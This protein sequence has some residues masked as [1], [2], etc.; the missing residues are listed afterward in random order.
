MRKG[1]T[2]TTFYTRALFQKLAQGDIA[3]A[4][5]VIKTAAE[6]PDVD[7]EAFIH[8]LGILSHAHMLMKGGKKQ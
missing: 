3:G 4:F 1:E 6:C 8:Y 7:N 5:H 2:M